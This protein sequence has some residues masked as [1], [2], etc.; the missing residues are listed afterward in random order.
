MAKKNVNQ[1]TI[2]DEE[3]VPTTLGVYKNKGANP[4]LVFFILALFLSIAFFMPN[5]QTY[6][7]KLL[8][9][10]VDKTNI[11]NNGNNGTD[12][13]PDPDPEPNKEVIKYD[14]SP[15]VTAEG[16]NIIINN[17]TLNGSLLSL[18]IAGKDEN[19]TNVNDIFLEL[20]DSENTF[21]GNVKLGNFN[22]TA[23]TTSTKTYSI[24]SNATK[25]SIVKKTEA[26]YPQVELTQNEN[27]ESSLTCTNGTSSYVHKFLSNQLVQE[28]Y[29]ISISNDYSESY[30]EQL[31]R[32]N[33][34]VAKLNSYEGVN[35]SV[36][37]NEQGFTYTFNVNLSSAD[38]S[39]IGDSNLFAY[40]STPAKV[41][42]ISEAQGYKCN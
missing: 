6:V 4:V 26:D 19:G 11:N 5:I 27:G 32:Y 39:L 7:N 13:E 23:S 14:I 30:N 9:K 37:S 2:K 41:K 38:V 12:P 40:K 17:I 21:L 35:A 42:F 29:T 25:F 18:T 8:G 15:D 20:F 10:D 36:M 1:V 33:T 34:E 16:E 31:N 3:L 28:T 24:N 22:A